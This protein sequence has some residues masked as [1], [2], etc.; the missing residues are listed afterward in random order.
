MLGADPY[1]DDACAA[2]ES[3]RRDDEE[4]DEEDENDQEDDAVDADAAVEEPDTA[5]IA[6]VISSSLIFPVFTSAM[7]ATALAMCVRKRLSSDVKKG[8]RQCDNITVSSLACVCEK[9][10]ASIGRS[11]SAQSGVVMNRSGSLGTL[12]YSSLGP[13]SSETET[14]P[15]VSP[16][17]DADQNKGSPAATGRVR[18]PASSSA[19]SSLL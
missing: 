16:C 13:S 14:G 2:A 15:P 11:A 5:A 12:T 8:R 19:L 4:E 10:R 3:S 17:P 1:D 6:F 9:A 18:T 7:C